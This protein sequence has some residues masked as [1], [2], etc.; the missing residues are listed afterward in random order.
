MIKQIAKQFFSMLGLE[1]SRKKRG[2]SPTSNPFGGFDYAEDGY[3]AVKATQNHSMLAPINLF[4]LFEQ[5]VYCEKRAIEG[6]FVECGVWKGGAVG[7]MAIANLRFGASRRPIH[8]FDAFSDICA[9]DASLDGQRAVQDVTYYAGVTDA[10]K[11]RGQLRPMTGFHDSFGGHGTIEDCKELLERRIKYPAEHL[12]YHKG[13]FQD[14][15]PKDEKQISKIAILRMDG[16][17]YDST[18]VC[19]AYLFDKVVS[20]GWLSLMTMAITTDV[21][22]LWTNLWK[23]D[24]SKRSFRIQASV[25]DTL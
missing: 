18:K 3:A 7:V 9:P 13:W 8:L 11:L 14:T 10:D 21:R 25:V 24:P 1:V 19:L 12:H 20:G 5:A 22:G 4:T 6:A 16:D 15:L 23:A 2:T 17:W